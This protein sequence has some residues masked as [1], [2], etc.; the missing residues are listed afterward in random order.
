MYHTCILTVPFVFYCIIH[1]FYCLICILLYH[2][3]STVSHRSVFSCIIPV[4]SLYH[5]YSTVSCVFFCTIQVCIIQYYCIMYILLC[6]NSYVYS[7]VSYMYSTV[8]CLC[9]LLSSTTAV[10]W[11]NS[12]HNN[13]TFRVIISDVTQFLIYVR[14]RSQM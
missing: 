11:R 12:R 6:H 3:Y 8:S 14:F 1:V 10:V 5:L 2:V 13:D 4:F 7:T 9:Y